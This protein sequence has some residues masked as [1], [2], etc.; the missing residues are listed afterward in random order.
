MRELLFETFFALVEFVVM[1]LLAT[2][3]AEI[4]LHMQIIAALH[5]VR[6]RQGN[7]GPLFY[8]ENTE[9]KTS[10]GASIVLHLPIG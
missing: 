7:I 10:G 8:G 6:D 5:I 4:A 2:A 9:W 3:I 1:P